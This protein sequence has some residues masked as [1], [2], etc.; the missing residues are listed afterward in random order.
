MTLKSLQQNNAEM[1]KSFETSLEFLKV[2]F[3]Y[4]W[5]NNI[6]QSL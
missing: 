3:S 5:L 4:A 1:T 2:K 6:N